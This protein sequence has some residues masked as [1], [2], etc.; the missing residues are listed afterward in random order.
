[1]ELKKNPNVDPKRNSTLYFQVGLVAILLLSY[2]GIELKSEDPREEVTTEFVTDNLISDDEEAILTL[3]PVQQLPPPP[4]P[5]PEV[6]E[7]VKDEI[8]LEEKKIETTEVEEN[9]PVV[10]VKA[11]EVGGEGDLD[12]IPDELPFAV[13]E[14]IPLFPGCEN[15]PKAKRLD[16][17]NEKMAAHIKKYFTYPDRAAEDNIQG[18][19]SVQFVIDK[20][21]NVTDIQ[22]RGPKNG[23]LLEK[24]A[25]RIISKLPKFTPGKQRGKPVKVKYGLPITFKLQ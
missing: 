6:I 15:V 8:K 13:I 4:P 25:Q 2:I 21:G 24:E 3:P 1:M 14:D 7:V 20:Q 10:V 11:S 22:M 17:F 18:R 9:K 19:V 23:E 16:C 5:A 12:D